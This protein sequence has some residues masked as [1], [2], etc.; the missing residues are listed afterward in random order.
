MW[1]KERMPVHLPS[2][3]M[4]MAHV[5]VVL[6]TLRGAQVEVACQTGVE[7]RGMISFARQRFDMVLSD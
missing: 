6:D 4:M 7:G 2:F 1:T 5:D 3:S